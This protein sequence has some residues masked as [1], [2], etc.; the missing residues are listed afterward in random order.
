MALRRSRAGRGAAGRVVVTV[1]RWVGAGIGGLLLIC[2]IVSFALAIA[3][4]ARVWKERASSFGAWIR[5]LALFWFNLEVWGR[6]VY[7][8]VHWT[9]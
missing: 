2:A 5:L 3:F 9:R 8:L 4:D 7:T 6:V 1:L